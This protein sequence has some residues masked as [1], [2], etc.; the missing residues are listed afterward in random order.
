MQS[1]EAYLEPSQT[2]KMENFLVKIVNKQKSLTAFKKSSILN[3]DRVLN[4]PLVIKQIFEYKPAFLE[5]Y[6]SFR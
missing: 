5:C 3:V 2:S 4:T 1:S 6:L